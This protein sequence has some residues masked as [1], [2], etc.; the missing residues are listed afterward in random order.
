[1]KKSSIIVLLCLC[2]SVFAVEGFK[3]IYIQNN[4]DIYIHT[5]Y[6]AKDLSNLNKLQPSI[7]YTNTTDIDD[8]TYYINA[9]GTKYSTTFNHLP[10]QSNSI[11]VRGILENGNTSKDQM[12]KQLCLVEKNSAL[13]KML[14]GKIAT[15]IIK[16][17]DDSWNKKMKQYTGYFGQPAYE[18]GKYLSQR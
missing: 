13:P 15:D 14:N 3:D 16:K 4:K 12:D 17:D 8:G 10:G 7:V 18:E 1:M 5:I 6:C 2:T 9:R 11:R